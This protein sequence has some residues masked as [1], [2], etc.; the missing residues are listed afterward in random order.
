MIFFGEHVGFGKVIEVGEA[1]VF[2]PEDIETGFVAGGE[3]SENARKTGTASS[4][5]PQGWVDSVAAWRREAVPF[6]LGR[7]FA[8][9]A[10]GAF[11]STNVASRLWRLVGL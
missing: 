4:A 6:A 11:A 7:V 10:F 3:R 9:A 8:P 1:F 2:E 5:P